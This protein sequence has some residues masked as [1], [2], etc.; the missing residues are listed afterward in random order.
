MYF[1]IMPILLIQNVC[2]DGMDKRINREIGNRWIQE[3][4][5]FYLIKLKIQIADSSIKRFCFGLVWFG[6]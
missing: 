5:D 1:D 2:M 6:H 4:F 3:I